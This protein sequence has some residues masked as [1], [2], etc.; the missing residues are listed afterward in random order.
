MRYTPKLG[1]INGDD[2][3]ILLAIATLN[4]TLGKGI[5]KLSTIQ[6]PENVVN[7]LCVNEST[8]SSKVTF[9][10]DDNL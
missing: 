6:I 10:V 4:F 8:C 2:N 1:K 5:S 9:P 3:S 7:E